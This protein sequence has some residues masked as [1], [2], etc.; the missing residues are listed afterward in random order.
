MMKTLVSSNQG[1]EA[2]SGR[3]EQSREREDP[4]TFQGVGQGEGH[5]QRRRAS[6]RPRFAGEGLAFLKW[7]KLHPMVR[8]GKPLTPAPLKATI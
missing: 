5:T 1:R 6:R 3:E 8:T 2:V 7:T 4:F